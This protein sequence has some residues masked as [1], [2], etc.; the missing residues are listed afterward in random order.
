MSHIERRFVTTAS[1]RIHIATAGVGPPVLLLH[2]TP[3][4]WDEYR[5]VLPILGRHYHAIAMDTVGYGESETLTGNDPS[6]ERWADA[7]HDLLVTLRIPRAAV[8]GHH[9]GAAI[10]V[11]LAAA[12]P[13]TV[14]A[15][16]LSA[17]PYTNAAQRRVAASNP[18]NIDLVEPRHDGA[19]LLELWAK[20][21]PLYPEGRIDLL[22]RFIVDAVKAGA[23]AAEGHRVVDRYEIDKR[24]PAL[25]C[26]ALVIA[27]T[28]D[29]YAYP[30][31]ATVAAAIP[32][33]RLVEIQ[34]GMVPLPDQMP[35]EFA[36]IVHSFLSAHST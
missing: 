18:H 30:H 35:V 1:G 7:V 12:F 13:E 5:E 26:P 22:E 2:Q 27:P 33:S 9:T 3:R 15:L 34:N 23:R 11:E 4:S 21:Q 14:G 6:I 17:C 19:H 10:A 32:G 20:R 8:V 25:R 24:L 36:E 29:P 28:A 31:A 16:V